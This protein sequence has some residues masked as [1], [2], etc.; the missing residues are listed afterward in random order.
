[1]LLHGGQSVRQTVR[2]IIRTDIRSRLSANPDGVTSSLVSPIKIFPL[3]DFSVRSVGLDRNPAS[4][5]HM[6]PK[7][8]IGS[9]MKKAELPWKGAGPFSIAVR[10]VPVSA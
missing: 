3:A 6:Q 7:V 10:D 4:H 8:V 9:V 5:L 1:M 2:I